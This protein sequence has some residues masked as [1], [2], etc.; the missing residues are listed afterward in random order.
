VTG[1]GSLDANNLTIDVTLYPAYKGFLPPALPTGFKA[2]SVTAT[3]ITV[4]WV[5][6]ANISDFEVVGDQSTPFTPVLTNTSSARITGLQ[7]NTYYILYVFP[8]TKIGIN[9]RGSG[10]Y[11]RTAAK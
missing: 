1:W 10:I 7:P 6:A 3:S 11:V 4:S 8:V 2:T 9:E 5:P